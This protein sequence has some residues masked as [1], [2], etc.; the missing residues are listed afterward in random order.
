[1]KK[2]FALLLALAMMLGM[3]TA[4]A[5]ESTDEVALQQLQADF[6]VT[7]VVPDGYTMQE[8]RFD[9]TIYVYF[10]PDEEDKTEFVA[11]IAYSEAYDGITLNDMSEEDKK[12]LLDTMDD[13]FNVPEIHDLTTENGTQVYIVNETG[14]ENDDADCSF[15]SGFTIY[16]GYFIQIFVTRG[17]YDKL[18]QDD[19]DLAM[20]ILSDM[21]PVEK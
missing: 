18:T 12:Q 19:I 1:M 20:K 5:T 10:A 7:C 21:W 3:T 17:D 11:S 6:D 2:I 4:M 15:A 13:D 9:D 14:A 16:K 8:H